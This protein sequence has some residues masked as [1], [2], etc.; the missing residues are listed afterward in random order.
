M[1]RDLLDAR[2]KGWERHSRNTS[3]SPQVSFYYPGIIDYSI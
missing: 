2:D 1:T 3:P